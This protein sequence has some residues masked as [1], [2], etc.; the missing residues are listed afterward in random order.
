MQH[1]K[2]IKIKDDLKIHNIVGKEFVDA[3]VFFMIRSEYF[4]L[5][6]QIRKIFVII[7]NV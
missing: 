1:K 3:K 5:K 4:K 2:K 7:K 6:L